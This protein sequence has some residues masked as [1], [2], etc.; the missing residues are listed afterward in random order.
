VFAKCPVQHR[1]HS[2]FYN[3][4]MPRGRL[5]GKFGINVFR[6]HGKDVADVRQMASASRR[7]THFCEQ[8]H[9]KMHAGSSFHDNLRML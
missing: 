1:S 6:L 4:Q 8:A 9:I 7:S 3:A 2:F 5:D